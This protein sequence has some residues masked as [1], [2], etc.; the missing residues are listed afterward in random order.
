ME[1][2]VDQKDIIGVHKKIKP[3]LRET[4]LVYSPSLSARSGAKVYLKM[5]QEQPSGSFK[6]RG[7]LAKMYSLSAADLKR[8][9]VA[10][11]TGNHAAAFAWASK[12]WGF[13]GTLFLPTTIN[14]AK[15][16]A[17]DLDHLELIYYGTHS[18]ATEAKARSY[19]TAVGGVLVH[20]YNDWQIICG[21]GT[22]GV[23][24]TAQCPAVDTVLVPIGG[25]G[26]AAGLCLYFKDNQKVAVYGCQPKNA[27][28]MAQSIQEGKI[29]PPSTLPTIADAA[30]GGLEPNCI[31]YHLCRQELAGIALL[32]EQQIKEAV[33]FLWE[34]H[35]IL[36][37]PTAA[38]TVAALLHGKA[39]VGKTVVAVIT[40]KKIDSQLWAAIQKTYGAH[41]K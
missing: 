26:L 24:I 21:Q 20:P 30:A 37:E 33:W 23:A 16:K 11:S 41:T 9:M 5:E 13:T 18:A 19:A 29:V 40:G 4:S 7:V 27:S 12:L 31:S 25:G 22:L 14:A 38:L 17:L 3:W 15:Q 36:V 8:P 6:L 10:A 32:K 35:Q 28:E 39:Y 1:A 34:Q 2:L